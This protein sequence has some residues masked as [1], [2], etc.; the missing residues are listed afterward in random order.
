MDEYDVLPYDRACGEETLAALDPYR[1]AEI[2]RKTYRFV[3]R[4]MRDP[5][6]AAKIQARAAQIREEEALLAFQ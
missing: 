2:G 5:A 1:R 3:R 4:L 6:V